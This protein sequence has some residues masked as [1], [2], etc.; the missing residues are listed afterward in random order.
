[1]IRQLPTPRHPPMQ[2]I[3]TDTA[4]LRESTDPLERQGV[5]RTLRTL[6]DADLILHLTDAARWRGGRGVACNGGAG[7]EA[8]CTSVEGLVEQY[9]EGADGGEAGKAGLGL[10]GEAGVGP[11]GRVGEGSDSRSGGARPPQRIL[12]VLSRMDLL[13]P[14]GSVHWQGFDAAVSCL[15]GEGI[16]SLLRLLSSS[17]QQA[18]GSAAVGGPAGSVL[19]TRPRQQHA[20][21]QAAAALRRFEE[22][23]DGGGDGSGFAAEL[24]AEELRAAAQWL[25]RVT[26]AVDTEAVL[27]SLFS[28]FCIGK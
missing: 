12:Q 7:N 24:A 13:Q 6:R 20:L 25:G 10:G 9:L 17:V 2:V 27:D 15:T 3:L 8:G 1:M 22:I 5:E 11:R 4:G 19:L 18:A 14:K 16:D 26:G 21:A 28:E 23:A